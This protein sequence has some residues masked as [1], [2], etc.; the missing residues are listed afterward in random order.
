MQQASRTIRAGFTLLEALL[1][2]SLLAVVVIGVTVPFAAGQQ[3]QLED[4]RR[5]LGMCLAQEL[6]EEILT[7]RFNDQGMGPEGT[8]LRRSDYDC[9]N[10]YNNYA[11]SAGQITDNC[12]HTVGDPASIGLSRQASVS[13]VTVSGQGNPPQPTFASISVEIKYHGDK[14]LTL[15]R[16]VYCPG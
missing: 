7:K 10:D 2:S 5:S 4:A 3:S 9:I 15:T 1:A 6:M 8:E 12:G 13:Y 11:E 14:L 16:L